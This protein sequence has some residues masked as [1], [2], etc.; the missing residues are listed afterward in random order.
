[1]LAAGL[2]GPNLVCKAHT[3]TNSDERYEK[4]PR[5]AVTR[6]LLFDHLPIILQYSCKS[7]SLS[8]KVSAC[9]DHVIQFRTTK[10]NFV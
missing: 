5:D 3:S 6:A 8:K 10:F 9:H 2:L 1:M 7:V 4:S